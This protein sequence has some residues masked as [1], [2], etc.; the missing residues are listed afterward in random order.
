M[1]GKRRFTRAA[2]PARENYSSHPP[3]LP[4]DATS[5]RQ[6]MGSDLQ[7]ASEAHIELEA[8][9]AADHAAMS[10]CDQVIEHVIM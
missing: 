1:A 10:S 4:D 5:G 8:D 6:F 2:L 3:Q 9:P 7:L